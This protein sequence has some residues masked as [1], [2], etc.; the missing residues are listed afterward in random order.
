MILFNHTTV[1]P[2]EYKTHAFAYFMH[3]IYNSPHGYQDII[4]LGKLK[5]KR[6]PFMRLYVKMSR[7][8]TIRLAF[9]LDF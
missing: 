4:K 2:Y 3:N 9:F 5:K 1:D 8:L 7:T 6:R